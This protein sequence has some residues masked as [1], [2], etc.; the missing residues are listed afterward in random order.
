MIDGMSTEPENL[1]LVY[2]RRIDERQARMEETLA[3]HG[4]RLVRI[5]TEIGRL[6][7]DRG[8]DLEDRAH[9]EARIDR[10]S[11]RLDRIERRLDLREGESFPK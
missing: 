5:E 2:L 9:L 6:V 10:F 7:R 3:E 4:R 8:G 11:E 1:L